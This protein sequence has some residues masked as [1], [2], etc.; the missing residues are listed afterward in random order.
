MTDVKKLGRPLGRPR[1]SVSKKRQL[2]HEILAGLEAELGR[3]VNP[4]EGLLRIGND[5]EQPVTVRVQCLSE[6]L[7]YLWPKLQSQA[8]QVTRDD[9]PADATLDITSI[10]LADPD[11]VDAAERLSLA[12]SAP[13]QAPAQIPGPADSPKALPDDR[14]FTEDLARQSNGHWAK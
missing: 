14:D 12:V 11:L 2:A 7:P 13:R 10:I 9:D 6:C 5:P 3:K 8:V 4:L 1:G